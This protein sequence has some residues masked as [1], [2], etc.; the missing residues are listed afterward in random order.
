MYHRCVYVMFYVLWVGGLN[1]RLS[2]G[3]DKCAKRKVD[4]HHMIWDILRSVHVLGNELTN[5]L[6]WSN[7]IALCRLL[8]AMKPFHT[9]E[10]Q[11]IYE[12]K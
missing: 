4:V 2:P 11:N 8:I 5:P 1:V 9:T 10:G 7:E 6:D 12:K 3:C